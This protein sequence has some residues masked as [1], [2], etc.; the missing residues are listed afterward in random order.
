MQHAAAK[1]TEASMDRKCR[2]VES[3]I[4]SEKIAVEKAL[5]DEADESSTLQR[6]VDTRLSIQKEL[7]VAE[8]KET[9]ARFE[10]FELKR[11]HEELTNN[12]AAMK[13]QNKQLV[14]PILT[15]LREEV[16]I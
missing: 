5:I 6:A 9:M 2:L 7:E 1:A 15:H 14:E 3:D 11:V 13:Q 12:L 10:L 8:Q 16:T 4:L